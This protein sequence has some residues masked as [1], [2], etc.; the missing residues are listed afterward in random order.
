VREFVKEAGGPAARAM[1]AEERRDVM[2]VVLQPYMEA[3]A[4]V[5]WE[6]RDYD[7]KQHHVNIDKRFA[8]RGAPPSNEY[9]TM[10][11]PAVEPETLVPSHF[12]TTTLTVSPPLCVLLVC[13]LTNTN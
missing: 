8:N 12:E 11:D 10:M 1:S 13:L 4:A 2:D 5:K 6:W 3:E 9:I 7:R